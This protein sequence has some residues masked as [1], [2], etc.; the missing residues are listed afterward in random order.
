MTQ[1]ALMEKTGFLAI[2]K[3]EARHEE[4]LNP[5]V[6]DYKAGIIKEMPLI[7]YSMWDGYVEED[8][9]AKNQEWIEFFKKQEEKGV[10]VLHLHTSGHAEAKMLADVINA[11]AP[12]EEIRPMH[13]EHP[14]LF[15]GLEIQEKYKKC[16]K[17]S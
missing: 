8:N 11:V 1:K 4:F 17:Y 13:T 6:E 5:F 3:P 9:K 14:E 2:I 12:E 7:I 15:E 10:E 16:I